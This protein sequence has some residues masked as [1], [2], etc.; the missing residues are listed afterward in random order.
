MTNPHDA[1]QEYLKLTD[2]INSFDSSLITVKSWGVTLGLAAI[3]LGFKEK[4]WGYFV[5]AIISGISFWAIEFTMK[6]HQMRYFPRMREIEYQMS[7]T[8]PSNAPRIDWSWTTADKLFLDEDLN[9]RKKP[10]NLRN[11][12]ERKKTAEEILSQRPPLMTG[13]DNY[14]WYQRMFLPHIMFPHV[15][16]I[17]LG[18]I[19]AWM[20]YARKG[21]FRSYGPQ[22]QERAKS[23]IVAH[24]KS[25]QR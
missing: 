8:D 19:F 25:P 24:R 20:A 22:L 10:K 9:G 2:I 4:N 11:V 23:A 15:F 17:A 3:G 1:L 7:S 14:V 5:L 13:Y 16:S 21:R 6:G 18:G 12:K